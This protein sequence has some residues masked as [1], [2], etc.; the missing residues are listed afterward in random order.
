MLFRLVYV[1]SITLSAFFLRWDRLNDQINEISE[2]RQTQ[3]AFGIKSIYEQNLNILS[4]QTPVLGPPWQIPFEF[5]LFQWISAVVMEIFQTTP[6]FSGRFTSTVFFLLTGLALYSILNKISSNSAAML[7]LPLFMFSSFGIQWG[8]AVLIEWFVTALVLWG[9][10]FLIIHTDQ[11]KI[12]SPQLTISLILLALAFAV[13]ITT[14]LPWLFAFSIFLILKS[15]KISYKFNLIWI[16]SVIASISPSIFWTK[17][18]DSIKSENEFTA[19]LTSEKLTAWNFGSLAQRLDPAI[20]ETIYDRID[21]VV[22]GS[23]IFVSVILVLRLMVDRRIPISTSTFLSVCILS[24]LIFINLYWAHEYYLAA[25]YPSLVGVVASAIAG[26][27]SSLRSKLNLIHSLPIVIFIVFLTY[28]SD[29]GKWYIQNFRVDPVA[30]TASQLLK[31]KTPSGSKI[32]VMGCDWDPTTL[33][34]A[35]RKGLMLIP[36]RYNPETLTKELIQ[37]YD[38]FLACN[39]EVLLDLPKNLQIK[40]IGTRLFQVIN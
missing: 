2:F 40:E 17:Y 39:D 14:P 29:L 32:L 7:S 25:I 31:E 8:S 19:W 10:Y 28:T 21:Q 3:T 5:P 22:V 11:S 4:A 24:P 6:E 13:K 34:Y 26:A 16:V 36:G 37:E 20:W 33:Y 35:E 23:I 15:K 1:S 27:E 18:A 9:V 30:P 12:F 38:Y